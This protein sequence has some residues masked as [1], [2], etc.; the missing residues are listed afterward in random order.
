MSDD[1]QLAG[2]GQRTVH[3]YLRS[4]RQLADYCQRSPAKVTESQLRAFFLHLKNERKFP[5]GSM[6]VAFS[7]IKFFYTRTSTAKTPI[8]TTTVQ[9]AIKSVVDEMN[10]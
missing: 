10:L 6:R 5:N 9:K 7:A 1:L 8:Q 2:M 3:G 4:V